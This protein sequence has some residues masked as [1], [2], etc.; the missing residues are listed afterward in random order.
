[1]L[2]E[3]FEESQHEVSK[4]NDIIAKL[5]DEMRTLK[6]KLKSTVSIAD[7]QTNAAEQL[8]AANK[9]LQTDYAELATQ[10]HDAKV[11]AEA[12]E[13]DNKTLRGQIDQLE[14]N[15]QQRDAIIAHHQRQTNV[16]DLD[17]AMRNLDSFGGGSE[18]LGAPRDAGESRD[19]ADFT[20]DSAP[21]DAGYVGSKIFT[22][23]F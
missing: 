3:R 2:M 7:D 9:R 11:H 10:A 4:A 20:F 15:I 16:K 18:A 6:A 17:R 23:S 5:Q 14:R 1:M 12:L 22:Q 21:G 13:R 19:N 8:R